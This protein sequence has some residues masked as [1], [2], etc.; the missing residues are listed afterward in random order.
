VLWKLARHLSAQRG[1]TDVERVDYSFYVDWSA[2]S[3]LGEPGRV[4]IVPRPRGSPLD[5]LIA[6]LMILV[7]NTW[8][9]LLA[10]RGA[11]G[12]YRTQGAGKVK[13]STRPG[14]HQGLGLSHYLWASSPL[15]RYSDLVNQRQ[16]LA[17]IAGERPPHPENDAELFA[18]LADFEATYAQ[19][20]EFQGRMEHY[21][22]LRWLLQ[23]RVT[24]TTTSVIRENLVRFDRLP[25]VMRLADLPNS[26]PGTSVRVAIGAID[27]LA[28]TL[29][30]R[31]AAS[32]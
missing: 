1:A 6:E 22:C 18:A 21:W 9:K 20:A 24:E 19:Y 32:A 23:E 31:V 29:E 17:V 3:G 14:E 5:R 10:E 12:L 11:T 25:L 26:A 30:C 27:L 16:L 2:D 13:M 8:G 28:A 4:A 7:N 15:R